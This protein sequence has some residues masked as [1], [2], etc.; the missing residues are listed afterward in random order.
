MLQRSGINVEYQEIFPQTTSDTVRKLGDLIKEC[1]EFVHIVGH[2]PG[3]TAAPD[4][5]NRGCTPQHRFAG[6]ANGLSVVEEAALGIKDH[7]SAWLARPSMNP[8]HPIASATRGPPDVARSDE[9]V[10]D[11]RAVGSTK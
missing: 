10:Q 7:R 8:T 11:L 5:L 4:V 6:R 3:D 1:P 2:Y 9:A